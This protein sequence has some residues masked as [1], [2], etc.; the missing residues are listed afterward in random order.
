[1]FFGIFSCP[2]RGQLSTAYTA[3]NQFA[4]AFCE[5]K[6]RRKIWVFDMGLYM[7]YIWITHGL[8]MD[9]MDNNIDILGG[10]GWWFAP[11]GKILISWDEYV[12]YMGK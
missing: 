7:G 12:Q 9:Y 2:P 4:T 11:L 1:M 6:I 8:Y 5:R 3:A 10:S